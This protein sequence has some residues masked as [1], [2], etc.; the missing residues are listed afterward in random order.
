[1]TLVGKND[2][3]R[4][5][6]YAGHQYVVSITAQAHMLGCPELVNKATHVMRRREGAKK[7]QKCP[8]Q[9]A[10]YLMR[11]AEREH[12]AEMVSTVEP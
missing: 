6:A 4:F 12:A 7:W 11:Q 8:R 2:S 9:A 5:Y 10:Y 1:M 3:C